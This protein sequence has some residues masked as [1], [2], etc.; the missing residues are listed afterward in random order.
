MVS[1]RRG[2]NDILC[3]ADRE[4]VKGNENGISIVGTKSG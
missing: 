3:Y 4:N 1:E 2:N